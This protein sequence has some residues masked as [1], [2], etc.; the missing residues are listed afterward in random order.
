MLAR[1]E[2]AL[3]ERRV[4]RHRRRDRDRVELGVSE[5]IVEV[6]GE[7]GVGKA[8]GPALA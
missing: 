5:E 6:G 3:R 7:A 2:H 8:P 4:G 1:I